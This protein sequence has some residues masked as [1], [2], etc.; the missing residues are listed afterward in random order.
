M[1]SAFC[2]S[3]SFVLFVRSV[4]LRF[5]FGAEREEP[6][7]KRVVQVDQI[8]RRGDRCLTVVLEHQFVLLKTPE[9]AALLC[10]ENS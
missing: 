9:F 8:E 1:V 3:L 7:S 5:A 10:D 6:E 2:G 4:S